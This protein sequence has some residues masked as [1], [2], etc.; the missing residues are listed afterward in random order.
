MNSKIVAG[1]PKQERWWLA[2]RISHIHVQISPEEKLGIKTDFANQG[3]SM[4]K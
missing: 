2:D 1:R 4:E 3:S